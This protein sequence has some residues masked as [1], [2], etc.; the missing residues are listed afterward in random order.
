MFCQKFKFFFLGPFTR[1]GF[2]CCV[3]NCVPPNLVKFYYSTT[4]YCSSTVGTP[5]PILRFD[6][7][8]PRTTCFFSIFLNIWGPSGPTVFFGQQKWF[9]TCDFEKLNRAPKGSMGI[10]NQTCVETNFE[11]PEFSS[12]LSA[13]GPQSGEG[14]LNIFTSQLNSG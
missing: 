3:S 13:S 10:N 5:Q 4:R 1:A 7:M 6:D 12:C 2:G 14:L 9:K 8:R 11:F